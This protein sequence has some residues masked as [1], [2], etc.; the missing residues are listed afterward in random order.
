MEGPRIGICWSIWWFAL[1]VKDAINWGELRVVG[2]GQQD[3]SNGRSGCSVRRRPCE[4]MAQHQKRYSIWHFV[5]WL[6]LHERAK[7][8][9]ASC[10]MLRL[11]DFGVICYEIKNGRHKLLLCGSLRGVARFLANYVNGAAGRLHILFCYCASVRRLP[12]WPMTKPQHPL[13]C[14]VDS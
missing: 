8:D 6:Q 1:L 3:V 7:I 13:I 5:W 14:L 10:N 4:S 12:Y 9:L 2:D 11:F